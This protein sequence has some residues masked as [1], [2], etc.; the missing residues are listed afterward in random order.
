MP[1]LTAVMYHYVRPRPHEGQPRLHAR[2]LDEFEAQ[3]AYLTRH[4]RVISPAELIG[5]VREGMRPPPNAC[6]LTFDDGFKD[7]IQ[8]VVPRLAD[9][10]LEGAFFVPSRVHEGRVLDV[11]KIHFILAR[12]P[13]LDR[14][15]DHV[16]RA[17]CSHRQTWG[18]PSEAE[19]R[20]R[21]AEP[22]R[23]DS[24][25]V[26]LVKRLL[27]RGLP[28]PVR[29]AIVGDL[30]REHVTA[31]EAAFAEQLYLSPADLRAMLEAGMEIGGHGAT[32]QWLDILTE[33]E[34]RAEITESYGF[35]SGVLGRAPKDWMFSY[36]YGEGTAVS[37]D[38]LAEAGCAVAF[39]T[40]PGTARTLRD[41]LSLPRL[42]TNDLPV[43]PEGER[44][45]PR[46]LRSLQSGSGP[47]P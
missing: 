37:R 11:H 16:F 22:G 8:H 30:F 19:L 28:A 7:H 34:Q 29:S 39:T 13:D 27:Q 43:G 33:E 42:D 41:P 12:V 35:L 38:R 32:H 45:H 24:A 25:S 15:A 26:I 44:A 14:L 17:L 3:L 23:F 20:A 21:Y 40:R 5:W 36:P 9:R 31:D 18:L 47:G 6:C 46:R 10:G 2:W 1:M 4:Y